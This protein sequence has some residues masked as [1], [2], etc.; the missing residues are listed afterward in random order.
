MHNV[1][2]KLCSCEGSPESASIMFL[3][4]QTST[5]RH[6]HCLLGKGQVHLQH[7]HVPH[8]PVMI[9]LHQFAW[10]LFPLP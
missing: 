9:L 3:P 6:P 5:E 7:Q 4:T 10:A 8:L 2:S 1:D